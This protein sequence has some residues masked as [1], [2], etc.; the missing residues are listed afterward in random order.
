MSQFLTVIEKNN[1]NSK[2]IGKVQDV[3]THQVL[4]STKEQ[5][6][7]ELALNEINQF[8]STFQANSSSQ[9]TTGSNSPISTTQPPVKKCCG[10]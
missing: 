6:S 5:D 9:T 2:F 1:H 7:Q 8:I 3:N 10:R 4:F